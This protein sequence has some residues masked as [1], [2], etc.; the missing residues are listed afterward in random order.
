[1]LIRFCVAIDIVDAAWIAAW[2]DRD[3]L[4][5]DL[6]GFLFPAMISPKRRVRRA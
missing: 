1:M 2:L 6:F 3:L 5:F 4:P